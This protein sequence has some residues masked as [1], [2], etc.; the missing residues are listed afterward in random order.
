MCALLQTFLLH[1][2][3]AACRFYC[4]EFCCTQLFLQT[5]L[6][7]VNSFAHRSA[8][9]YCKQFGAHVFDAHRLDAQCFATLLY[10][11][12][13]I[14]LHYYSDYTS[15]TLL[16]DGHFTATLLHYCHML[17][18]RLHYD[19]AAILHLHC[20]L[21]PCAHCCT[22]LLHAMFAA[23]S[24]Y[25]TEF[26]CLQLFVQTAL[27]RVNSFGQ[28]PAEIYCT[29]FGAH[30]FDAHRL[31]AQ[32]FATLLYHTVSTRLLYTYITTLALHY[33]ASVLHHYYIFDTAS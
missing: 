15:A 30:V 10:Y 3:V 2:A 22:V 4:P 14:Q 32:C 28:S 5:A 13:A 16:H 31:D 1:A 24:F 6:L 29:Q 8:E 11:L 27:L 19:T 33:Y 18:D 17:L 7:R 20:E 25:C 21:A 23:C 9:I 26:C 12:I